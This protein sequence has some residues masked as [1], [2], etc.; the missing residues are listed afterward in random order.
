MIGEVCQNVQVEKRKGGM[1]LDEVGSLEDLMN[2]LRRRR[3]TLEGWEE[4]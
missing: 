2:T 1:R 4:F 3:E